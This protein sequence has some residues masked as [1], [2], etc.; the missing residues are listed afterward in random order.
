MLFGVAFLITL[1]APSPSEAR[2]PIS[3][4]PTLS[5]CV[6]GGAKTIY[7]L[8]DLPPGAVERLNLFFSEGF[9]DAGAAFNPTDEIKR[10]AVPQRRFL[11]AYEHGD[12]L[13]VWYEHGGRSYQLH[14]LGMNKW[15]EPTGLRVSP[16][17]WFGGGNSDE[18]CAASKAFFSGVLTSQEM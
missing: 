4:M 3:P 17:A 11:R 8:S 2:E 18:L 9:A 1:V 14:A 15:P 16:F 7:H 10:P 12:K 13:I 6:I 5:A